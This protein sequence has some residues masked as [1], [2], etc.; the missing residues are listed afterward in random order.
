MTTAVIVAERVP[1]RI[2]FV[3]DPAGQSPLRGYGE[4]EERR[5]CGT[6]VMGYVVRF[7][8]DVTAD[9]PPGWVQFPS[10]AIADIVIPVPP[11]RHAPCR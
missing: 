1:P 11:R 2:V 3:H 10:A 7:A 6:V 5:V 8:G 4:L 9:V